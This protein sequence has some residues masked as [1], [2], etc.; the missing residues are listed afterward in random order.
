MT[1]SAT[2]ATPP[3]EAPIA[4]FAPLLRP[5]EAEAVAGVLVPV[6]VDSVVF[7]CDVVEGGILIEVELVA[8]VDRRV[9][10]NCEE[11]VTSLHNW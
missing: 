1:T 10:C 11:S 9:D 2:K 3:I 4:A 8:G 5:P 7:V 6:E